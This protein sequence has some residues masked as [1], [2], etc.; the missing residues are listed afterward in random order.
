MVQKLYL[1]L[2]LHAGAKQGVISGIS[3]WHQILCSQ[4]PRPWPPTHLTNIATH[5]CL[6]ILRPWKGHPIVTKITYRILSLRASARS[7]LSAF[8]LCIMYLSAPFN[9]KFLERKPSAIV[10]S[11]TPF[12]AEHSG[13]SVI[14]A[15]KI[16]FLCWI[17][18]PDILLPM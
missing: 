8:F 16:F 10:T 4:N 5:I 3:L 2:S 14:I 11:V 13:L 9:W 12:F 18:Q 7:L 6:P 1:N 17:I 15:P